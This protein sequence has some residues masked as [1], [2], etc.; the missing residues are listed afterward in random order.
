M[1]V[2]RTD[3]IEGEMIDI[4]DA[5]ISV[6]TTMVQD[7]EISN[8]LEFTDIKFGDPGVVMTDEYPYI[9]VQPGAEQYAK[10]TISSRGY[11]VID[12]LIEIGIVINQSDYFDETVSEVSG[13]RELVT[14]ASLIR[15]GL[16][17]KENRSLGG[18]ARDLKVPTIN[19][20]PQ[21]RDNAFVSVARISLVVQRQYRHI[22]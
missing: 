5:I 20:D 6:L 8:K 22:A 15:K 17:T 14:V 11:D 13:L 12:N 1:G 10:E 19:Y 3:W 4:C 16:R 21:D 2:H 7:E 18:I 9:Y